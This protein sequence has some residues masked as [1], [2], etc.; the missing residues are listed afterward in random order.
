MASNYPLPKLVPIPLNSGTL[1]SNMESVTYFLYGI[2][3]KSVEKVKK[4]W[5]RVS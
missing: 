2:R 5:E 1:S 4:H 3:Y